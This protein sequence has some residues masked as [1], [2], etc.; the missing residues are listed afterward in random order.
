MTVPPPVSPPF[1][2]RLV[3]LIDWSDSLYQVEVMT[4][5][6]DYYEAAKNH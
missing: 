5:N 6:D 4:F 1:L 3:S 2:R